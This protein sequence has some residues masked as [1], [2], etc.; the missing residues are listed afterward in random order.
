MAF[1]KYV[2]P[3]ARTLLAPVLTELFP[4]ALR[5]TLLGMRGTFS[6]GDGFE[7]ATRTHPPSSCEN[8]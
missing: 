1:L 4:L 2:S 8:A 7:G 3:I 5:R 6:A